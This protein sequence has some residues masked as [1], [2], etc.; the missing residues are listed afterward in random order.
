MNERD[1][2][3]RYTRT[4]NAMEA[5]SDALQDLERVT[6]T[7]VIYTDEDPATVLELAQAAQDRLAEEVGGTSDEQDTVVTS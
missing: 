3:S 4:T 6:I 5:L 7:L 1:M 2:V